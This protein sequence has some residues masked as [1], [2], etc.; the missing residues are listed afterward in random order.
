MRK[1]QEWHGKTKQDP[2]GKE[3]AGPV[4]QCMAITGNASQGKVRIGNARQ[5]ESRPVTARQG[6]AMQGMSRQDKARS[7]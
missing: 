2:P 5:S 4:R 7:S 1:G 6:K 3:R